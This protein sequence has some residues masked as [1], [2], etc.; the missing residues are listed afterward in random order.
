MNL[1]VFSATVLTLL[2]IGCAG[3]TVKDELPPTGPKGYADFADYSLGIY[4]IYS[5]RDN[6]KVREGILDYSGET[7]RLARTPG[8]YDFVIYHIDGMGTKTSQTITVRIVQN[9]LSF[10]TINKEMVDIS[11][12]MVGG[13]PEVKEYR[14]NV[15]V[16]VARK[17]APLY[18][19]SEP[20]V[21]GTL[22]GLLDD[23]DWR[24]RSYAVSYLEKKGS[25]AGGDLIKKVVR[26][27]TDDPRPSNRKQ[28]TALAK[29]H[30]IDPSRNVV[31]LENFEAN[32]RDWLDP[33]GRYDFFYNDEAVLGPAEGTCENEVMK[34]PVE[35]PKDV[36]IE[37][38]STRK[39]GTDTGTYGL[40]IGSDT[41]NFYHIG[42]S[43]NGEAFVQSVKNKDD[44]TELI[45]W[46]DQHVSKRSE[47]RNSLKVE[48]RGD[49]WKYYVNGEF[50]GTI[51]N[52]MK[53][54]KYVIGLRV[55]RGQKIAFE[56]LKIS[57]S[58]DNL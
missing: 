50:I 8:E 54:D 56:Q 11:E 23:A 41:G 29:K 22:N 58:G 55:C 18:F 17:P 36:D 26:L 39:S 30:G 1:K 7:L 44:I 25:A 48:V 45:K 32:K 16:S 15:T 3:V 6:Q 52:A 9:M 12:V 53:Q 35:L 47:G 46:S 14:Y 21:T 31:L 57:R 24:A 33:D 49:T 10:V 38:T 2:S 43:G 13:R 42:I 5:F 34:E 51:A 37:L 20:D 19:E 4:Y 28:A 40:L 27:A